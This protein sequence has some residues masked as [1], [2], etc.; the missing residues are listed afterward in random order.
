MA[1][2]LAIHLVFLPPYA[3]NLN[4]IERLWKWVKKQCLYAKYYENFDH[5]TKIIQQTLQQAN[6][7]HQKEL[8]K[9]LSLKFQRF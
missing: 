7:K 1:K 9:L 4:C 3:A 5:F 6:Q 8:E 2:T